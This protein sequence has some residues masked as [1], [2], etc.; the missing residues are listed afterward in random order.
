M[1]TLKKSALFDPTC[2]PDFLAGNKRL[3]VVRLRNLGDCILA[4]PV[5]RALKQWNPSMQ[6]TVLAE[7]TFAPVYHGNPFID[8][9]EAIP[10]GGPWMGRLLER[11]RCAKRLGQGGFDCAWNLHGGSTSL[12]FTLASRAPVR[13]GFAHYRRAGA[14]THLVPPA[15]QIW[16]HAPLHTLETQLAPLKWMG[17]I[18]RAKSFS[19]EV[20]I[21]ADA[22]RSVDSFLGRYIAKS[23]PFILVQ[24]T[25]TLRTKQWPEERFA[26]LI[27]RIRQTY[28]S[29][30]IVSI[31]PGEE[32]TANRLLA[33]DRI[34]IPVFQG[35]NLEELKAILQRAA[36][37]IGNDSGP[38]H[39]AAAL[40]R[41]VL[42]IFSSSNY[43]AWHPWN[44]NFTAART[45][46]DC[47]PC[48]GYRCYEY[49]SPRCLQGISVDQVWQAF[50]QLRAKISWV[51]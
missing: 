16:D 23:Q 50:Q 27:L 41:P 51:G 36:V 42:A 21:T 6:I 8:H 1:R 14:Y 44:T 28:G 37:Y 38:M 17:I 12:Y 34:K 45:N 39:L 46:L 20:F 32:A 31:G 40:Q 15:S 9:I 25:A 3:L 33:Y 11:R 19:P 2:R 7:S 26:E 18:D 35:R 30:I 48:P 49:E 22:F 29:E 43:D 13:I 47:S 5:F 10:R 24:P 4:T